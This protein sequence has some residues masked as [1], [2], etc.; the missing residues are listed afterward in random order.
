MFICI[1][2]CEPNPV[3]IKY[4][5]INEGWQKDSIQNFFF[6]NEDKLIKTNSYLILRLNQKYRYNNIF[7]IITASNSSETISRDTIE[8][9]VADN[10]GKLIGS[11]M[12]NIHE[13]NLLH[14]ID[15]QLMPKEN[16][17]IN[18]EH[19]MRNVN[20]TIGVEKLEGVLD[21]GYKFEKDK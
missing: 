10:F 8:Y 6:Q 11:K 20:E 19:A 5:S 13:L 1:L 18:I 21:V 15:F 17:F 14:K 4:N 7:V 16:Y 2:S 3:F 12:I 9:D